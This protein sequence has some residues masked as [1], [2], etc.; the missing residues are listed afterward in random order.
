MH[1]QPFLRQITTAHLGGGGGGGGGGH[2]MVMG[3]DKFQL[4]F[5]LI[6]L[7]A[8][9]DHLKNYFIQNFARALMIMYLRQW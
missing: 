5:T 2:N 3:N 4:N 9:E 1:T 7:F 8:I 6:F